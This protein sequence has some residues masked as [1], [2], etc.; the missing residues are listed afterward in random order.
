MHNRQNVLC[1]MIWMDL[2]L[3]QCSMFS[4]EKQLLCLHERVETGSAGSILEWIHFRLH[5]RFQFP[6]RDM[7]LVIWLGH[8]FFPSM[9]RALHQL[10]RD[11]VLDRPSGSCQGHIWD[12]GC[13]FPSYCHHCAFQGV[14]TRHH[15][16]RQPEEVSL[17]WIQCLTSSNVWQMPHKLNFAW[18]LEMLLHT[19]FDV[20]THFVF[21]GRV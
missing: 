21:E 6:C 9:Q 1:G 5:C 16:D 15:V 11:G 4:N 18:H 13:L 20:W 10:S 7:I 12:T 17:D 14:F 19:A 8:L 2:S 3:K